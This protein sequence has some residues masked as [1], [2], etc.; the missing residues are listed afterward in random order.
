MGFSGVSKT[1]RKGLD[2][3]VNTVKDNASLAAM[4]G[5]QGGMAFVSGD[6]LTAIPGIAAGTA[7]DVVMDAAVK[8]LGKKITQQVAT[9][10]ASKM[11]QAATLGAS[12]WAG[13]PVGIIT[14]IVM[15][16]QM[17][18]AAI[19][20]LWNP[21]QTYYNA[22]LAGIGKEIE[23][24]LRN[25]LIKTKGISWPVEIK[26]NG[27]GTEQKFSDYIN[28]YLEIHNIKTIG[29]AQ[30]IVDQLAADAY[31]AE[32]SRRYYITEDGD[33][34]LKASNPLSISNNL[35]NTQYENDAALLALLRVLD[36]SQRI[37]LAKAVDASAEYNQTDTFVYGKVDP[38]PGIAIAIGMVIICCCCMICSCIIA[39]L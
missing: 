5:A 14:T 38:T 16:I 28:E 24:N 19:D 37:D 25:A 26:P 4:S 9:Q 34:V 12:G 22:D 20:M 3:T 10:T 32:T 30:E 11:G 18:G 21:F 33:L 36:K 17:T 1:L 7:M 31:E 29:E 2:S 39:I 23:T 27:F 35:M 6:G 8:Q 13:G 15:I